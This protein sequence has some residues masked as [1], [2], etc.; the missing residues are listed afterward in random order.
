MQF[1]SAGPRPRVVFGVGS[2]MR[3]GAELEKLGIEAA[4][5]VG[6]PEQGEILQAT[7]DALGRRCV[8]V[9]AEA[10]M[11]VPRESLRD[12]SEHVREWRADGL[13]ALGGGSAIGLAK[14]LTLELGLP[15]V[16]LP[17]TYAGSEMTTIYG[18][19]D[20]D[21]K[22]TGRDPRVAPKL[23]LYDPGLTLTLTHAQAATSRMKA[24]AHAVEGLYAR[25]VDPITLWTAEEGIRALADGLP[26]VCSSPTDIM[27]RIRCM[28]GAWLCGSVLGVST[29]GLHHRLCHILGGSFELP[30]SEVHSVVLPYAVA[31]NHPAT[32]DAMKR[33]ERALGCDYAPWGLYQ[34]GRRLGVPCS[35]REIGMKPEQIKIA[36]ALLGSSAYDNPRP[37]V[38][39]E[40]HELIE[41]AYSGEPPGP[42]P[43]N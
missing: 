7:G 31:Y 3:L 1:V 4:C 6:S 15:I 20:S 26:R 24:L 35:L 25:K 14:A 41:R 22:R 23:V 29:M 13:V 9:Y 16:A 12:A 42:F 34:L 33:L 11:H 19:S 39:D 32:P 30:H 28:Y 43:E 37:L 36:A 17:T 2:R 21:G 5:I 8:G 40:I 27:V 18:I 38:T 10:R